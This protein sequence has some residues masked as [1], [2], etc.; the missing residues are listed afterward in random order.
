MKLAILETDVLRPA[1]R[2]EYQGYGRMFQDLFNQAGADW[3]MPVYRVIDGHYPAD[4]ND[5]DAFLITGS[6]HDA[7]G[8]T[9]WIARLRDYVA[10]LYDAGKPILGICFGHQ[11]VAHALGGQAGR[12]DQGWGMGV[13]TYQC[14]SR[15]PF[16]D[17]AEPVSL[18][19]SHRDQVLH[20]PAGAKVLLESDFCR[21]AAYYIGDQVLCFQGHPEFTKPYAR[22]LLSYRQA[23]LA[24]EHLAKVEASWQDAHQGDRI[25]R[26]MRAFLE[27]TQRS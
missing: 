22:A 17:S 2:A 15:P 3:D 23:E 27:Q 26:W 12:A 11:L 5:C 24:P 1:L 19:V 13:M 4:I 18:L 20:L 14:Q 6:Q 10:T 9:D 7:F 25:A 16:I 8:D 21:F